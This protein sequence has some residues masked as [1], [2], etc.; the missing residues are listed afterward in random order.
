MPLL[1]LVFIMAAKKKNGKLFY[2]I[3]AALFLSWCGDVLLQAKNMFLPGLLSFLLAHACYIIYFRQAGKNKKGYLQLKP[4]LIILV[5]LYIVLLLVLLFPYLDELK[6]PVIIYSMTIGAMLLMAINTKQ[7]LNNRA[8]V[9][10]I[11]GALLFVLSDSLLAVNLFVLKNGVL[12]LGV[13]ATYTTAQ[14]LIVKGA[15]INR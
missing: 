9:F 14:Y 13:M 15:L 12:S 2:F 10:F 5:L 6:I 11:T 3:L 8:P 7:Q 1:V 4:L